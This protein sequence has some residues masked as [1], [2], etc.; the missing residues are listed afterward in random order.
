M[1]RVVVAALVALGCAASAVHARPAHKHALA[2]YFGSFLPKKLNDCRTCH[3]PDPPGKTNEDEDK[4]HN[5]FGAR[6]KATRI[7]LRKMARSATIEASLEAILEEDADGDGV[8]NRVEILTGHFPGDKGDRPT[9]AQIAS[10]KTTLAEFARLKS[11]YPWRPFDSVQRPPAPR[12]Q[13][14]AW[15]RNPIDAF[16]AAEHESLGLK[17]RPEAAPEVLLRRVYL[18]LIGLPPTP[19]EIEAFRRDCASAK[20]QANGGVPDAAWQRVVDR[21]LNDPRHGERWGRHWMDVWRYSD[22][23]GYGA[24]VRDS[25]PHIWRWRDWIIEA[26]NTDKGYDR[27]V[28]EMLAGDEM[29]PEDPKALT[30][31]GYLVRNWKLLSREKWL[32]DTVEHTA[33]AFLGVTLQCAKCH[34]H[35]YDPILQKDYYQ[36]RAIFEPHNVRTDRVPGQPDIK[37]DGLPRVYDKDLTAKT[38][39]FIRGDD[40]TPDKNQTIV[41][42]V[43]DALGGRFPKVEPVTLP[44]PAVEPEKRDFVVRESLERSAAAVA[45]AKSELAKWEKDGQAAK[46]K[47]AALALTAKESSHDALLKVLAAETLEDA[48]KINSETW[49]QAATA[50]LVA[51]RKAAVANARYNL[52]VT[53]EKSAAQKPGTPQSK[54]A[55]KALEAAKTAL[56]K[57]AKDAQQPATTAYQKRSS[58][59]Y[60]PQSTGRRLALAKWIASKDNPL[61]ARVAVNHIWLRHFGQAIVPTVF[62][63]GKNG[64]P[65]SHPALLDWLAAEFMNPTPPHP[66]L[67]KGGQGGVAWSMKHIHRLIVT[68]S[69]YRMAS[70]PDAANTTLDRDNKYLWRF[71]PRRLEAEAVRDCIFYVAGK[72]DPAMGGPDI[73]YPLGLTAPRR[74][75]YFRHAAEKEMEFLSI[76][77]AASVTECYER[78]HSIIPQQALALVNSELT[79]KHARILARSIAGKTNGDATAFAKSAF[80]YVLSRQPTAAESAE[81]ITFLAEQTQRLREAKLPGGA[82]LTPDGALPAPDPALRAR[83][84]LVHVLLNHH[85]FVTIR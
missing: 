53:E 34:D 84:N 72:L 43:P 47:A 70:T 13:N 6:L 64:R 2:Q 25:Q 22:W 9:A 75:L 78:K 24:Q 37:I 30:G 85:E 48:G 16:L 26:L 8:A 7:A 59:T 66:P 19:D 35:M 41:P 27:M 69:A 39:F 74:S 31:T 4:P 12:V 56:A 67:R 10:A 62:D 51:Q 11:G 3:L 14:A 49:K 33:Q 28:L 54:A 5:S 76:F 40:R 58:A 36:F 71:A 61:T 46:A 63:F 50:A 42:D 32:Q 80:Q 17:P 20:P 57:A 29:A 55:S 82:G 23:A 77:D 45:N 44:R 15:V 83:E 81:C 65:P 79:L 1:T 52:H 60:P 21:L 73:D 38:L 18:D 68:S